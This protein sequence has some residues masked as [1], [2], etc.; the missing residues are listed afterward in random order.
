M[1]KV[2]DKFI[3]SFDNTTFE[4]V[5]FRVDRANADYTLSYDNGKFVHVTENLL[6]WLLKSGG[7]IRING[8]GGNIMGVK[9]CPFCQCMM[10][11]NGKCR[12][13]DCVMGNKEQATIDQLELVYKLCSELGIDTT[14]KD[15]NKL[16]KEKAS[17]LIKKL[18]ARKTLEETY[19]SEV[20]DD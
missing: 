5:K 19:G 4:V 14:G 16:T 7:L 1:V 11:T 8:E 12:N 20:D 15:P 10:L 3:G 2:G 17:K 9:F 18:I 6:G 13:R